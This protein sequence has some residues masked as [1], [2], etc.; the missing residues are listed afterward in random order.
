MVKGLSKQDVIIRLFP[1]CACSERALFSRNHRSQQTFSFT[2]AVVR[3]SKSNHVKSS[4]SSGPRPSSQAKVPPQPKRLPRG[5]CAPNKECQGTKQNKNLGV[6]SAPEVSL[7]RC[8]CG[9]LIDSAFRQWR[10]HKPSRSIGQSL[11]DSAIL[12]CS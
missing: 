6:F 11:D 7:Y 12:T 3:R 9:P 10:K 5:L 1:L 4:S 2:S 8:N